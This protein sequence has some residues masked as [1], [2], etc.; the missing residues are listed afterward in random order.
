MDYDAIDDLAE[1]IASV[2]PRP[3]AYR[4]A[5]VG[6]GEIVDCVPP[7]EVPRDQYR[8]A[9]GPWCFLLANVRAFSEPFG[10][11]GSLGLFS[12]DPRTEL[13]I[14]ATDSGLQSYA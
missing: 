11:R 5:I 10:L 14:S 12:I 8:W 2:D 9:V 3:P 1:V 4:G 7:D 13:K 6:K